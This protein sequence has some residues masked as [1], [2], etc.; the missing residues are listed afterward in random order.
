MSAYALGALPLAFVLYS[1][2]VYLSRVR[3]ISQA[4]LGTLL[5]IPPVGWEIGYFFW[6]W[7]ADRFGPVSGN[8]ARMLLGV[9]TV[10]SLPLALTPAIAAPVPFMLA[11]L[12]AMFIAAGFVILSIAYAGEVFTTESSGLIAGL[13]AGSWSAAVALFM[14]VAGRLFDG[15][16]YDTAF[17]VAALVPVAGYLLWLLFDAQQLGPAQR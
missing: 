8:K 1:S 7:I 16:R 2:S 17:L 9:L 11:L 3:A 14:P 10:L 6:G 4:E 13:G 5:W 12:F 15:G